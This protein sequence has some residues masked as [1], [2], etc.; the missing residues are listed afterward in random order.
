MSPEVAAK[1]REFVLSN[2][3]S[4][5]GTVDHAGHSHS[6]VMHYSI[7]PNIHTLYFSTDGRSEKA[8]NLRV[9]EHASVVI[10]WSEQ[11]WITVQMRGRLSVIASSEELRAAKAAHYAVHPNSQK[12][13]DDP[14]TVFLAFRPRWIRYSDLGVEPPIIQERSI[15]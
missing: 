11:Y 3:L 6:S 8:N 10:G 5:V 4:V 2:R 12:F 15:S 14:H 9:N 1:M 13:E 7:S